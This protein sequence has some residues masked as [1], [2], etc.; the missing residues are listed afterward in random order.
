MDPCDQVPTDALYSPPREPTVVLGIVVSEADSASVHIGD[1]LREIE[2]W[3]VR[4][5]ERRSEQTGGGRYWTTD[6]ASLRVVEDLHLECEGVATAFDDPD[7]IA[8]VSRHSGETG[9]LLSAHFTG[10]L[11]PAEF[12]GAPGELAEA[13]PG[14]A[15]RVLDTLQTHAPP[16]YDV[17]MECTHH[18]PSNVGAPSLFVEVGSDEQAWAD[19]AAATAAAR[20]TLAVRHAEIQPART[21]VCIGGGHYAPRA[22]RVAEETD[23]AVGHVAADWG[24]EQ[25]S[26]EA[27]IF[28]QLFEQS[29]STRALLDGEAPERRQQVEA[30]GYRVV[31]ETWL[32]ET[33]GI[34]AARAEAL[35]E[36]LG[37]VEQGLR[38]G[39]DARTVDEWTLDSLPAPFLAAC[40]AVDAEATVDT[41]AA[42]TVAYVTEEAG[43]RVSGA[44]ALSSE[45]GR[46]TL[47]DR[48]TEIMERGHDHVSREENAVVVTDTQFD[49]ELARARGVEEGPAFGRLAAGE[50]VTVDGETIEPETVRTETTRRFEL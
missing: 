35:E 13:A 47:L 46:S 9:P 25:T 44:V 37:P 20:A 38:F 3:T 8:F 40:Q 26:G 31:S 50:A 15:D 17:S 7:C 39:A 2:D 29:G 33:R 30:Q 28:E 6:G 19:E 27:E 45:D 18:G 22:T 42:H 11:G 36:K 4:T 1:R 41:V 48:L 16:D 49:P 24:L 21:V 34:P 14:A 10:N 23:W 5:D 12:G 43:N 32:R